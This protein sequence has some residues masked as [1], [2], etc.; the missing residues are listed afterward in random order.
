MGSSVVNKATRARIEAAAQQLGYTLN[1]TA[2]SLRTQ[3]TWLIVTIVPDIGNPFYSYVLAGIEQEAQRLGYSVLIGNVAGDD[4]RAKSYGDRL[5]A[6]AADGVI[7]LTGRLP[8]PNWFERVSEAGLPVVALCERIEGV[9]IPVVAIDDRAAGASMTRH[10]LG[11]GHSRIAHIAGTLPNVLSIDRLAGYRDALAE[12]GIV[13]DEALVAHGDFTIDSGHDALLRILDTGARPTAVFCANDEMAIGAIN[14][15]R[16]R[17]LAAPGDVSVA[18]CDGLEFGAKYFP[19]ITTIEQP[20]IQLGATAM[21]ILHG[22][23]I[24]RP[25]PAVTILPAAS[26]FRLSTAIVRHGQGAE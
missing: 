26:V 8:E 4:F 14:A 16:E 17:G 22:L 7:L 10:L 12:A 11:L 19:P 3:K 6:G 5:L 13:F 18:G 25:A 1:H 9:D 24:G 23:T 15:L 2:R 21:S 20:R